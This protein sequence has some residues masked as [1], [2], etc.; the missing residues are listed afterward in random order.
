MQ[1]PPRVRIEVACRRDGT[2]NVVDR[3]VALLGGDGR[4]TEAIVLL[5]GPAARSLV[6]DGVPE[7]QAY[8]LRV[9]AD[10]ASTATAWHELPGREVG[11]R[12]IAE[13]VN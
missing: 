9:S 7:R 8:W 4:D 13:D 2:A 11:S 5:G 10:P 3:C 1:A 6:A 12:S